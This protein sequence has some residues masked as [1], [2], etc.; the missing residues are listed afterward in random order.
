MY[1]KTC[2][3]VTIDNIHIHY[4]QIMLIEDSFGSSLLL[5]FQDEQQM[6]VVLSLPL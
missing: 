3:Q 1:E 5:S 2:F 4:P 6:C